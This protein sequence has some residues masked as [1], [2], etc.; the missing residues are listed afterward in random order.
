MIFSKQAKPERK[1][2]RQRGFT[3]IELMIV[4][5]I[6]GILAAIAIPQYQNYVARS[7]VAEAL[8]FSGSA[9]T[10]VSEYRMTEGAFPTTN[11]MAGLPDAAN[12]QGTY[13]N[14]V[15]IGTAGVITV[16]MK[17]SGVA[18]AIASKTLAMTPTESNGNI[19]WA[20]DGGASDPIGDAYLPSQCK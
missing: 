12:M 10:A 8:S 19:T 7:Q 11:A 3:L 20:C 18:S 1:N 14:T 17:A 4:V 5:A 13:V 6:I 15:T 2:N 16:A 9:K